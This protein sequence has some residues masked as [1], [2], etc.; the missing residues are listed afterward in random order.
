MANILSRFGLLLL[1]YP[2]FCSAEFETEQGELLALLTLLEEET[3]LATQSKMNADYVPG[4]LTLLHG[5]E[6][7]AFGV[8]TVA[9]ALNKVAGFY[10]NPGNDGDYRTVV[11]GIGASLVGNNL[12]FLVD[13]VPVNRPIDASTDWVLRLPITQVERIEVIR[14]PGAALYG[15][16]AFS[17]VINII[18]KKATKAILTK[19]DNNLT[20]TDGMVH[21]AFDS[22][23]EISLNLSHWHHSNS[24][25]STNIDNFY[26]QN[27]GHSPGEIYDHE[28]GSIVFLKAQHNDLIAKLQYAEVERGGWY[29]RNAV[30]E[31]DRDPRIET[32]FNLDIEKT[33]TLSKQLEMGLNLGFLQTD[34]EYATY[35]PIPEGGNPS[36]PGP[37]V[38]ADRY[39][40]DLNADRSNRVKTFIH[41][42]GVNDH[43]FYG[44]LSYVESEVTDSSIIFSTKDQQPH[45]GTPNEALV[46]DGS[47]RA[48][49]SVTLQ[50]QWQALQELEITLGLRY[51][52]Y[53]DW[54]DT[55][56]P[57]IAAVWRALDKHIFKIQY[58]EAFRPPSIA[59]QNP[60]PNTL[61]GVVYNTLEAETLDSTELSYLHH[62]I[63]YTFRSTLFYTEIEN[64]IEF[65]LRP[66]F[67]PVW[68]NRE[69]IVTHG[70]EIEWEQNINRDWFWNANVS[71]TDAED[72]R[73]R[74][75]ILVGSV[76]WLANVGVSW[77]P[78]PRFQHTLAL[79]YI[80]K[81]E[82]WEM[83]RP[84]RVETFDSYTLLDYTLNLNRIAGIENLSAIA[85][86]TN[87]T[88]REYSVLPNP[89]QYP[90]GL[91]QGGRSGKIQIA[92]TFH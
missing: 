65:Y 43:R 86:I 18:P 29:G 91:P 84:I 66:S 47:E 49:T 68:R 53:D 50:D 73:D 51:D 10:V 48:L 26:N 62:G 41:W 56:S 36:R 55:T 60:G 17:G 40:Q 21:H 37:V 82:G 89:A 78:S 16:F 69:D 81:Q 77:K 67:P 52:K 15:E 9:E 7:E 39:R 24:S 22:G 19:G 74:D 31:N 75:D 32:V 88:D 28:N 87:L 44:E 13:G 34:I 8:N 20:Q 71:Y 14:G 11:R 85:S 79:R 70:A 61:P 42:N 58:A 12:K 45:E 5:S 59:D 72:T 63:S 57:R 83:I 3:E 27:R 33:W 76:E 90:Y 35:L 2:A 4:M 23:A 80:G 25:E 38:P 6:L 46:L 54:G 64:L 30:L 92:Y 1:L